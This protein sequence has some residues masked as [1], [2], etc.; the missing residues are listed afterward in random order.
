VGEGVFIMDTPGV[1]V[2]YLHDAESMLKL[3]LV[4]CVKPGLVPHVTL[5]DYLLFHLN[6]HDPALYARYGPPTNEVHEFLEGVARRT[7]KLA[8]GGGP[9][10]EAAADWIVQQ[11]RGGELGRFVLDDVDDE[12]LRLAAEEKADP[13]ISMTQ[14]RKMEKEARKAR[15]LAKRMEGSQKA[16]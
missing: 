8:K 12:R 14:R 15:H 5:A 4:G 10:L 1:F 11:W 9:S 6:R 13:P 3:A 2:P 16:A 7:G